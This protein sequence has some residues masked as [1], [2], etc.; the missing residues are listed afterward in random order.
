MTE[1]KASIHCK[2]WGPHTKGRSI[3]APQA[4]ESR[5]E[6]YIWFSSE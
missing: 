2:V 4:L 1:A 5:V 6:G 3:E